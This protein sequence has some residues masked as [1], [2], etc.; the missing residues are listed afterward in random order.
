MS[1]AAGVS[2]VIAVRDGAA[3]IGEALAS[4]RAQQPPVAE[5]IVVDDGSRDGTAAAVAAADPAAILLRQP[6]SGPA[7]AR[8]AGAALARGAFLAFLDHDDL[9]PA[10]RQAALL[11]GLAAA[12]AAG[13]AC[14]RLGLAAMPGAGPDAR[15]AQAEGQHIPFLLGTAL[16][17]RDLWQAVGGMDP[18]AD[19]AE[20][21]DLYL[22]LLEHGMATVLVEA[23]TLIYRLHATNR[24]RDAG[25]SQGAMLL[26][27]RAAMRRRRAAG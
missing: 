22:R 10:G 18:A 11:Q 14:G 27:M 19:H 12:P 25:L 20:D 16:L 21:L 8:N 2:A 24:S 17:R 9:W 1:A 15:L 4:I 13:M 23:R 7:A 26:A 5:V 3:L 6:P